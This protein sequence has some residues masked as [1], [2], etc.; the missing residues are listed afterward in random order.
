[1]RLAG[2]VRFFCQT[3]IVGFQA[4]LLVWVA[5]APLIWFLR[6]GLGPD[7]VES[8]WSWVSS[9]FSWAGVGRLWCWQCHWSGYRS[10]ND[11]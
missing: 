3:L 4:M 7:M 9:S 10:L 5:A 8:G 1:M 6:Y 11:G 2:V